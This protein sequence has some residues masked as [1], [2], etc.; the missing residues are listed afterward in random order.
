MPNESRRLTP[1]E[2]AVIEGQYCADCK[3]WHGGL[4]IGEEARNLLYTLHV[5][6]AERD[7]L[8]AENNWLRTSKGWCSRH[9]ADLQID[10]DK[11]DAFACNGCQAEAL[12]AAVRELRDR[13]KLMER[14]RDEARKVAMEW[15]D[16]WYTRGSEIFELRK[17][18]AV[19]EEARDGKG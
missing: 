8:A 12:E 6:E 5:T 11:V 10:L 9:V 3:S 7:K 15:R 13:L 17:V 16:A 4:A 19:K 14:E 1:A 2:V 18:L